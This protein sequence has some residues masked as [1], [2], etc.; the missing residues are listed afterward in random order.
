MAEIDQTAAAASMD[1]KEQSEQMSK[2]VR[3][4]IVEVMMLD[5]LSLRAMQAKLLKDFGVSINHVTLSRDVKQ[6]KEALDVEKPGWDELSEEELLRETVRRGFNGKDRS[7]SVKEALA[8]KKDLVRLLEAKAAG[9]NFDLDNLPEHE[10]QYPLTDF[11]IELA[12]MPTDKLK[13]WMLEQLATIAGVGAGQ[14]AQRHHPR[15]EA[16]IK[17]FLIGKELK[18][19]DL[20]QTAERRASGL[21]TQNPG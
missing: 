5:K 16:E 10:R 1:E 6:I 4:T 18:T 14:R 3:L 7:V 12:H 2:D 17:P 9:E 19:K 8:A 21:G 15:H 13:A 11:E 20:R